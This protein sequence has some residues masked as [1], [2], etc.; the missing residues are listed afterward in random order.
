MKLQKA[1]ALLHHT[2]GDGSTSRPTRSQRVADP[3]AEFKAFQKAA[4]GFSAA[5]AI[6]ESAE[7]APE[8]IDRI[9]R[10]ALEKV[11]TRPVTTTR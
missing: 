7:G 11:R 9:L 10:V 3:L 2:L 5:Q 8:E 1:G 4:E 6:L